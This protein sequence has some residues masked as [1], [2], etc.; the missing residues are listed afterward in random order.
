MQN[1][2]N[3][4]KICFFITLLLLGL[5]E[6]NLAQPVALDDIPESLS[7]IK[8]NADITTDNGFLFFAPYYNAGYVVILNPDNE[9]VFYKKVG[10][11]GA[12]DFKMHTNGMMSYLS[13][14]SEHF[15]ILNNKLEVIDSVQ[16]KNGLDTDFHDFVILENGNYCLLCRGKSI[17]DFSALGGAKAHEVVDPIIQ[18]Q[19]SLHRVKYEWRAAPHFEGDFIID[20][21]NNFS[22]TGNLKNY[23]HLNSVDIDEKGNFLVSSRFQSQ[24]SYVDRDSGEIL[25]RL[26]GKQSEFVFENDFGF[27]DQHSAQ[28]TSDST[29]L[30]FDNRCFVEEKYSRSVEYQ[31]DIENKTATKIWEYVRADSL[32]SQTMGNTQRLSN[33]NTLTSWGDAGLKP[34]RI[35][36]INSEDEVV[37]DLSLDSLV[38]TYT[39]YK[40]A[41]PKIDSMETSI[42]ESDNSL[43][44]IHPNPSSGYFYLTLDNLHIFNEITIN[45]IY[46]QK[47]Y[48]SKINA[49]KS[50]H[51]HYLKK[52][53]YILSFYTERNLQYSKKLIIN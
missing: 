13:G 35:I 8:I 5:C 21:L 39:A 50:I 53:I 48:Q 30:L 38:Y 27:S 15:I 17:K 3:I 40:F 11:F 2:S 36:E 46:G 16:C 29:I 6:Q 22:P 49:L 14:E 26:G 42:F 45:N 52:G 4:F 44:R 25:W 34:L 10:K 47:V 43:F 20:A 9:I 18:I 19:D 23:I 41:W 37:F 1:N 31:L 28:W 51:K 24:I 12:R 32:H 7:N 33:G